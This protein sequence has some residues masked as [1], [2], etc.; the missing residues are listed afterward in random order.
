MIFFVTYQFFLFKYF[1]STDKKKKR[2]IV[3]ECHGV[4]STVMMPYCTG[5]TCTVQ[6]KKL[7]TYGVDPIHKMVRKKTEVRPWWILY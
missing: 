5:C 1:I 6:A 7:L 3:S 4:I 2:K